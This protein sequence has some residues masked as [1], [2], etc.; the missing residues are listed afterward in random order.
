M[1]SALQQPWFVYISFAPTPEES[2]DGELEE[3][4]KA[5]IYIATV[6]IAGVVG[7]GLNRLLPEKFSASQRP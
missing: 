4:R 2:Y 5:L 7:V 6:L 1:G 3:M